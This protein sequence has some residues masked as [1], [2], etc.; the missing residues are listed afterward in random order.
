MGDFI[1]KSTTPLR[2]GHF[3]AVPLD[4]GRF[5]CGR[6]LE[7]DTELIPSPRRAFFGGLHDWI[8]NV[9]PT[10]SAIADAGFVAYGVMHIKAITETGGCILGECPLLDRDD[11]HPTLLSAYGGVHAMIL[12]GSSPIRRASKAEWGQ[13]PVLGMWGYD[14]IKLLA[15]SKLGQRIA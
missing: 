10:S 15:E 1:P 7:L 13:L 2:P 9:P 5:A 6:V 11:Y 4:D 12:R 14:F 3:W 8:D